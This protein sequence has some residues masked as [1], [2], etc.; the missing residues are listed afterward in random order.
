MND[1]IEFCTQFADA[2]PKPVLPVS[3]EQIDVNVAWNRLNLY[4]QSMLHFAKKTSLNRMNQKFF[5]RSRKNTFRMT[6]HMP[7]HGTLD[8]ELDT[9]EIRK[10]RNYAAKLQEADK[11]IRASKTGTVEYPKSHEKNYQVSSF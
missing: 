1:W 9:F 10:L 7:V 8:H 2:N 5:H 11:L 3:F 6:R 4:F